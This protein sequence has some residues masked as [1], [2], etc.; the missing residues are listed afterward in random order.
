MIISQAAAIPIKDGL[1]FEVAVKKAFQ[2]SKNLEKHRHKVGQ[3]LAPSKMLVEHHRFMIPRAEIIVAAQQGDEHNR[4]IICLTGCIDYSFQ[5][6][7]GQTTF[8]FVLMVKDTGHMGIEITP[9][10][11]PIDKLVLQE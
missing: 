4:V 5:G 9:H 8:N 1:D 3:N 6:G 7:N 2:V 11:I 10:V